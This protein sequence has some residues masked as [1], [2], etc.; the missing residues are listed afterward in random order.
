MPYY[1]K[2]NKQ[3]INFIIYKAF[4][5]TF[6]SQRIICKCILLV[7]YDLYKILGA[8]MKR[9]ISLILISVLIF[10][11]AVSMSGCISFS[12]SQTRQGPAMWIIEDKE[13]H[14]CYLFGT[15]H[16]AKNA[17]MYPFADVIEDAYSYCSSV[18]V[19]SDVTKPS[20]EDSLK[21]YEYTD[22]T[23]VKDHISEET[24]NAA[25]EALEIYEGKTYDNRYD[26]YA[27]IYWYSLLEGYNTKSCGYSAE[28]GSDTYFINKAENDGKPVTELESEQKQI[29]MTLKL[30][31]KVTEYFISQTLKSKGSTGLDYYDVI[32]KEGSTDLLAYSINAGKTAQYTDPALTAGMSEYYDIMITQRNKALAEAVMNSLSGGERVFYALNISRLVGVDGVVSLLQSGGYRV[33]RK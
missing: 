11:S 33:I 26:N 1:Y 31:D 25:I 15:V 10:I 8:V 17:D 29:E 5:F 21:A 28:Y 19:E 12:Y 14:R 32:Y 27:A 13:G 16:T 24:Y 22:G 23:T 18:A 2:L 4:A 3:I 9:K 20:D 7:Y 30:S 6:Y